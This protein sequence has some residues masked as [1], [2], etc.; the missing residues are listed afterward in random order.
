[1]ST[2][3][4]VGHILVNN[5]S[6]QMNISTTSLAFDSTSELLFTGTSSGNVTS[7][8]SPALQRYTSWRARPQ[9]AVPRASENQRGSQ[10][11]VKGILC[12]ERAVYSVVESGIK[13]T[14]RRGAGRWNLYIPTTEMP[15]LRLASMCFSPTASSDIVAGGAST[16]AL[17]TGQL[18][19]DDVMISLNAGTGSIIRKVSSEAQLTHIRKSTR[20]I[21]A[22]GPDGHIQ[23]R[24]PR[25]LN[26][27]HR[28]HAH[29]GGVIDMQSEGNHL[30]SIG[31]TL[32]LGH[33]MVEAMVKVHD[34][35]TMRALAPI[36]FSA[37]GGP[38]FLALNPKRSSTFIVAAL[39]GQF[40]IVDVGNPGSAVHQCTFHQVHTSTYL[41][42]MAMS[43][44]ADFLAFGE[45]DGSVRLWASSNDA[46]NFISFSSKPVEMPDLPENPPE[47]INWTTETSLS[48]VGLPYYEEPLLSAMPYDEYFS[49]ASPLFN[50]PKKIDPSI[51]TSI[52]TVDKV[53]YAPLPR[54]L[55]G[56]R[57]VVSGSGPGGVSAG[58]AARATD[59]RRPDE[60]RRIGIPLFRSEK[61][62]A[63]KHADGNTEDEEHALSPGLDVGGSMPSYYRIK[64]IEYSRF[65]VE[66]FDFEF[67][68]KTK[69]SGLETHIENSYAN[70]YLQALHHLIPFRKIAES[71]AMSSAPLDPSKGGCQKDDCLLCQFGFLSKMLEDAKGANCQATNFLRSLSGSQ[72]A[73][74]MGL[75]DKDDASNADAAYSSLIQTFN[76]FLLETVSVE[77]AEAASP[78]SSDVDLIR[79]LF[80]NTQFTVQICGTCRTV[81]QRPSGSNIVDLLYPR[82]AMSNELAPPSDFASILRS[83]LLRETLAKATC[84]TCN[85]PASA[86]RSQRVL[87]PIESL[88]QALSVNC[89]INTSDQLRYWLLGNK[90]RSYLPPKLAI[91]VLGD[92]VRVEEIRSDEEENTLKERGD[93]A[94]Y[95]LRSMVVQVQ[96]DNDPPHLVSFAKIEESWY[97]FNDFLVRQIPEEEVLGFSG[98]WKVP[99]V[100]IW[101]R[102][103]RKVIDLEALT[104][105]ADSALLTKDI[106][107]AHERDPT[108]K[109]HDPLSP[110]D[111]LPIQPGMICPIDSEFV[112]LNQEELEVSSTGSR[113]LI[114]PSRLSLARVSVLRGQGPRE[115]EAFV[116]DFILTKDPV[117]DYLTQFSGIKEGDLDPRTSKHTLVP[118]RVAYKKLRMLVDSGC[119]FLGHGLKKDFRIINIYVPPEQVIDTVD[120]FQ[121]SSHP[122]KLSLR[123]LAWFLLKEDIQGPHA[124]ESA[125]ADGSAPT[126]NSEGHDSIED[127]LAALRLYRIYLDFKRDN[128]L[129]DVLEDLYEAGRVHGWKPPVR[130]PL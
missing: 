21:C 5:G 54:N 102:I 114:R 81:S 2:W 75:M 118:L 93:H 120:L 45:A 61:E 38:A 37:I 76:R 79:R 67:Y 8:Y 24:D 77:S 25:S 100:L 22:G 52:R 130:K 36:P 84:R 92:G 49:D 50:P 65:G 108:L 26:L 16:G 68:N 58:A 55:R 53:S 98:P 117:V 106:T 70:A 15:S 51:L 34:L 89:A 31:W 86:I 129:E 44:S 113:R 7:H 125:Q 32:R 128:R 64:T 90:G 6:S 56:K 104:Q 33:P 105:Q 109:R 126:G 87:P 110:N 19:Q 122:R 78:T 1:M 80:V 59:R 103:D 27:E 20:Y 107:I 124:N 3:A 69:F 123:F 9:F 47:P 91:S 43:P 14:I 83:S 41:T 42:S 23:L 99:A 12:D 4:E 115:G 94:I 60:R 11:G 13:S 121:S 63:K 73:A 74:S 101:E 18:G 71:H 28:L 97:L 85:T 88:P 57:N 40:Q 66:D 35:R 127:A 29:P 72:R 111:E 10:T 112:A 116:D 95:M 82:K 48:T 30:Y 46:T 119:I 39:H 96:A 17:T 62:A